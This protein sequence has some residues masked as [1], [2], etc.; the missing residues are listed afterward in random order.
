M[1]AKKQ[2]GDEPD[3]LEIVTTELN[4]YFDNKYPATKD[5]GANR[6]L[7]DGASRELDTLLREKVSGVV[8]AN[9][10]KNLLTD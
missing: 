1:A 8:I 9:L 6:L 4:D 7:F 2:T 10:R 3:I 5:K